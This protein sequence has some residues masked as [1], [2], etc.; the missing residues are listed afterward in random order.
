MG[1]GAAPLVC[2]GKVP[3]LIYSTFTVQHPR[4]PQFTPP[5]S[6]KMKCVISFTRQ[7][8]TVYLLI[9]IG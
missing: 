1:R 3:G 8:F 5:I 4:G 6:V 7:Y 9:W 2:D